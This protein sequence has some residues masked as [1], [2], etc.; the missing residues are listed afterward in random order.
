MEIV[1]TEF[2]MQ[3]GVYFNIS[4]KVWLFVGKCI[5]REINKL[6]DVKENPL[7]LYLFLDARRIKK[8]KITPPLRFGRTRHEKR[9]VIYLPYALKKEED[10]IDAVLTHYCHA[11]REIL[12]PYGVT[13]KVLNKIERLCK[14]EIPGNKKYT[15]KDEG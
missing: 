13:E 4:H 11:L 2:Y 7:E 3:P 12:P 14:K 5:N 9:V 10:F 15:Y 8:M 1:V 6:K